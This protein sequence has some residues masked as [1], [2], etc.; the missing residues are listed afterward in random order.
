MSAALQAL[1]KDPQLWEEVQL[2]QTEPRCPGHQEELALQTGEQAVVM[3]PEHFERPEWV[4]RCQERQV[5][6]Q[7]SVKQLYNNLLFFS[8][9]LSY[10]LLFLHYFLKLSLVERHKRHKISPG[11]L[12]LG[13]SHKR[14][15]FFNVSQDLKPLFVCCLCSASCPPFKC[16]SL[17]TA[18]WLLTQGFQ[19][20]SEEGGLWASG[21]SGPD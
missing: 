21:R 10:K 11:R 14:G 3:T 18:P 13:R 7:V 17:I 9:F 8:L 12:R 16:R 19:Q 5:N 6:S 20:G 2:H 15:F 1:Q 4:R